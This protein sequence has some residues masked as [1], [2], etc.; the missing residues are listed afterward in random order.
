MRVT[1]FNHAGDKPSSSPN[2]QATK[3]VFDLLE[4][5]PNYRTFARAFQDATGLS[6]ALVPADGIANRVPDCDHRDTEFC[7]ALQRLLGP[8]APCSCSRLSRLALSTGRLRADKCPAGIINVALPLFSGRQH[9]ATLLAGKVIHGQRRL[10]EWR[11]LVTLLRRYGRND[12]SAILFASRTVPVVSAKRFRAACD[13][14][15]CF[16]ET[17]EK[18]VCAWQRAGPASLPVGV[19]KT[20]HFIRQRATGPVTL[21]EVARASGLSI[22]HFSEVFKRHTGL[23]FSQYL[24]RERLA[25]AQSLLQDDAHRVAEIAFAC[26]FGSITAFNRSFKRVTGVSP[27]KFRRSLAGR[28]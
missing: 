17:V 26:G 25:R 12:R 27:T 13:L 4:N 9:I 2:P 24:A 23:T 1:H 15:K 8:G 3:A 10:K 5:T 20:K 6:L 18:R 14:L 7:R 11:R 21:A 22:P 16:A 28:S 19:Q